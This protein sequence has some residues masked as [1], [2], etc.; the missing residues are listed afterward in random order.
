MELIIGPLSS[1]D[2]QYRSKEHFLHQCA[3]VGN[4]ALRIS[5]HRKALTAIQKFKG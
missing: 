4:C 2:H 5:I 1:V 3:S